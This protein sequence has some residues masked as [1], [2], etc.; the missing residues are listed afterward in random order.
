MWMVLNAM[1]KIRSRAQ[2]GRM[3]VIAVLNRTVRVC[4]IRSAF[5]RKLEGHEGV[6]YADVQGM[7]QVQGTASEGPGVECAR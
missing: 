1:D 6:S 3:G 5:G 4:F 7:P 2:T